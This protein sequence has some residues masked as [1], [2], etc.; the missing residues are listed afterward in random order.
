MNSH[1]QSNRMLKKLYST[2]KIIVYG[3]ISQLTQQNN[4]TSPQLL[5]NYAGGAPMVGMNNKTGYNG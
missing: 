4:E 1:S 3:D 2:P 5:D